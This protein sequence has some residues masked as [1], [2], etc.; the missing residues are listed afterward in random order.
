LHIDPN[1]WS[2]YAQRPE[3]R[4]EYL[5]DF[6]LWLGLTTFSIADYRRLVHHLTDL[7]QQTDRG[8]V[9]AETLVEMLGQ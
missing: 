3:T 2:P 6:Q 1:T 4:C 9:L 8:I 7:A 5:A